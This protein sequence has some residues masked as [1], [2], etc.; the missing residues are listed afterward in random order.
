[1]PGILAARDNTRFLLVL[2]PMTV[3]VSPPRSP[4]D[5]FICFTLTALQGFGG[6]MAVIQNEL[7]ERRHWMTH[8]EF[9]E[10]WAVAQISPG[11]NVVNLALMIGTRYFGLRGALAALAGLITA[12]LILLLILA[13]AY[14]RWGT[15]PAVVGA[16]RGMGAVAAGLIIAAGLRLLGALRSNPLGMTMCAALGGACFVAV[17]LL[18]W[19]QPYVLFGLGA[20]ACTIAYR[21][22][23]A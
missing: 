12:P 13:L 8:E 21:R 19:P 1:M 23:S 7:V 16:L 10:D 4:G 20:V 5:L 14:A 9:I 6:V 22:L 18:R 11:P 2:P 3:S 17:A 15:Q